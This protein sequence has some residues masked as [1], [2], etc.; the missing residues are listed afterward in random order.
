M[1]EASQ[2]AGEVS[3]KRGRIANL[4]SFHSQLFAIMDFLL[5]VMICFS[6]S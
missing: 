2:A 4:D 5:K 3:G 1:N 6:N